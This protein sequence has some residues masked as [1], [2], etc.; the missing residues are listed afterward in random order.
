MTGEERPS[1]VLRNMTGSNFDYV[2]M[3]V[4]REGECAIGSR[5][6]ALAAKR[7]FFKRKRSS[8]QEGERLKCRVMAVG[9]KRFIE[10]SSR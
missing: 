10:K 8:H 2:I 7:H 4:D 9:A 1:H 5:R 3:E 6:M